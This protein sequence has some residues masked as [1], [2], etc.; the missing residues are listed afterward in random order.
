VGADK[1]LYFTLTN[2]KCPPVTE[3]RIGLRQMHTRE[4]R[5][6]DF[7]VSVPE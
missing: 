2:D 7:K 1:K 6:A 4:S 5:Y 3:G